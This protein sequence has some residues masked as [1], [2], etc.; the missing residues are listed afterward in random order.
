VH[1]ELRDLH[2]FPTRRSS[3]LESWAQSYQKRHDDYTAILIKVIA[4]RFAEALAEWLHKHVRDVWGFGAEEG[5]A[6]H[7]TLAAPAG[8]VHRS[9]E[10]TSELQSRE[11]LVCRL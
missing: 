9:E 5:F 2:S 3:D 1:V 10:H 6:A 7:D 8:Q 4:D 11:N